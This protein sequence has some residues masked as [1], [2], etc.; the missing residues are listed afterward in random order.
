MYD[1]VTNFLSN[2]YQSFY[3]SHP[4]IDTLLKTELGINTEKVSQHYAYD[5][6]PGYNNG[7]CGGLSTNHILEQ[8]K[9]KEFS[10]QNPFNRSDNFSKSAQ[11]QSSDL[12][13]S[14]P[15]FIKYPAMLMSRLPSEQDMDELVDNSTMQA[16]LNH[17]VNQSHYDGRS[18]GCLVTTKIRRNPFSGS[19]ISDAHTFSMTIQKSNGQLG[20]TALDSNLFFT[21][22]HE[23]HLFVGKM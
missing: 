13:R 21:S 14:C 10:A 1:K 3:P 11:L 2:L 8:L 15:D 18:R 12:N 17:F 7:I 5:G 20:C 19:K 22:A 9:S 4:T 23:T 16:S 6:L